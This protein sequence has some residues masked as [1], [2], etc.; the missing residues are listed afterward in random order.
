MKKKFFLLP[1]LALLVSC[2]E[3]SL[4]LDLTKTEEELSKTVNHAFKKADTA[5]NSFNATIEDVQEQA[6]SVGNAVQ[7]AVI[8]KHD[9][10]LDPDFWGSTNVCGRQTILNQ[11]YFVK[12]YNECSATEYG[13]LIVNSSNCSY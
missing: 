7:N 12:F 13:Y 10:C 8:I 3:T 4:S 2:G 5:V 9:E 6:S 1:L 11:E